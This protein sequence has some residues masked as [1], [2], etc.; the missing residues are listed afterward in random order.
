[1]IL[2]ANVL[3]STS[4][5]V[6]NP[7]TTATSTTAWLSDI[8]AQIEAVHASD[9]AILPGGAVDVQYKARVESGTDIQSGDIL[10]AIVLYT[11]GYTPWPG[12]SSNQSIK[13][14]LARE[15]SVGI[16]PHRILFLELVTTGGGGTY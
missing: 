6:Y 2:L 9:L 12:V 10:T 3:I 5:A 16:L 1:M 13:V 4:R 11:D 15:A 14:R 7:A 8:P